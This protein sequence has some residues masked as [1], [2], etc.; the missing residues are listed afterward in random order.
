[1]GIYMPPL[2]KVISGWF[3]GVYG[4]TGPKWLEINDLQKL[5]KQEI[6]QLETFLLGTLYAKNWQSCRSDELRRTDRR[7]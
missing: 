3:A 7:Q 2:E 4:G 1:M 6:Y 5:T